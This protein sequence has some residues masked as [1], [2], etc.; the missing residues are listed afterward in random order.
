[1]SRTIDF[2]QMEIWLSTLLPARPDEMLRMEEHARVHDFPIIGALSGQVCYTLARI[3]GSRRVFELGSGYG[4]S[5]AWF[6]KA[7]MDNEAEGNGPAS[8]PAQV[9]HCVWDEALS[10]Q[11]R[12]HLAALGYSDLIQ[13][14]VGEA[15]ATLQGIDG[16]F[17]LIFLDIQKTQY[18]AALPVI[19]A[20]LRPGGM[21]IIDNILWSGRSW[22][23]G[24]SEPETEAIRL[25]AR[26]LAESPRWSSFVVPVR[27]GLLV[28]RFNG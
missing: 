10:A 27:D 17:D 1:M 18:P 28:A 2:A 7:V 16:P 15:V 13:F 22:E 25:T 26:M 12:T 8:S 20:A 6:A 24:N 14:H 3:H 9:H 19:E 21:L 11:A 5:T 23:A 4:Y